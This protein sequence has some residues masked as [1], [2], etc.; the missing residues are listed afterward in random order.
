MIE[1]QPALVKLFQQ[2]S[3]DNVSARESSKEHLWAMHFAEYGRG[4]TMY[5]THKLYALIL[6]GIPEVL[7]GEIWLTFSGA[8]NEVRT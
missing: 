3:Q 2:M 4:I 8:I 7:R 5:R 6:K 1:L